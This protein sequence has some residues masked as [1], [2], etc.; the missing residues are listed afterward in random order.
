ML[1]KKELTDWKWFFVHMSFLYL[2]FMSFFR[3]RDI[4]AVKNQMARAF[5]DSYYN[6]VNDDTPG[7]Y[8]KK[9]LTV[10]LIHLSNTTLVL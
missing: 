1:M 10:R 7:K 8:K 6:L 5:E 9:V 3:E 2:L 4:G